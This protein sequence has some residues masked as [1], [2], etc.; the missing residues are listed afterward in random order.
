MGR[1]S[2]TCAVCGKT[3]TYYPRCRDDENK[4]TWMFT[5]CSEN[6]RTIYRTLSS[7]EDGGINATSA[8]DILDKCDLSRKQYFG[9]SYQRILGKIEN[10]LPKVEP[11][12]PY[13]NTPV[14]DATAIAEAEQKKKPQKKVS[15]I[16]K[17]SVVV[18]NLN[19]DFENS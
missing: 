11:D 16:M 4:P 19:G 8:K 12:F 17:R 7:Y 13:M 1:D 2:R 14:E 15:K 18:K 10:D 9:E 6:C 3:Y 5:W